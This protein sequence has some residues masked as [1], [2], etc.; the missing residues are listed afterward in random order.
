MIKAYQVSGKD[1]FFSTV[2]FAESRGKARALALSTD[3]CEDENFID[4]KVY[5][6]PIADSQYKGRLEMQWEN[7]QDRLFLVKECG[8]HC[9]SD[10]VNYAEPCED[11]IAKKYCDLYVAIRNESE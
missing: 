8:W 4:V 3:C 2:V 5:R 7:Q 6:L 10:Y 9:D 11:C 1:N